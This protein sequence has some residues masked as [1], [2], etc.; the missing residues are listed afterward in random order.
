MSHRKTAPDLRSPKEAWDDQ[1][2]LQAQNAIGWVMKADALILGFEILPPA[3]TSLLES[4]ERPPRLSSVA[5]MLAGYAVEVLLKARV[6]QQ[7]SA[8]D[9]KGK[10]ALRSHNLIVLA[11]SATFEITNEEAR[12][13]E[14]LEAF[15]TWAGR[16]PMPVNSDDMRPRPLG[17]DG[18]APITYHHF[19]EEH[20]AIRDLFKRLKKDLPSIPY[21]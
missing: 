17:N 9:E 11:E 7:K 1:Y 8:M 2:H 5:Y 19:G 20:Q 3:E 16:Y 21:P 10:F 14:R 6:I 13:L 15:V 4:R 18:M 12:L